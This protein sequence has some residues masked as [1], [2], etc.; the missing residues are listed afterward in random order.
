MSMHLASQTHSGATDCGAS[1]HYLQESW[2]VLPP[3]VREAVFTLVDA[4]MLLQRGRSP[5]SSLREGIREASDVRECTEEMSWQIAQRCRA[6]IQTCLREEEWSDADREF[7]RIINE[8]IV[9]RTE[10]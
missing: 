8:E 4:G 7:F 6:V 1:L 5:N 2:S 9:A 10:R 3:H